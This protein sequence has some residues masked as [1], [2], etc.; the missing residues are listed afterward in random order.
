MVL[1]SNFKETKR[2][3]LKTKYQFSIKTEYARFPCR[4]IILLDVIR[5]VIRK[6]IKL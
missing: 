1:F 2:E 3:H 4:Q 6:A 5:V